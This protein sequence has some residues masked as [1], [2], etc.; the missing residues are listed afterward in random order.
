MNKTEDKRNIFNLIFENEDYEDWY[1]TLYITLHTAEPKT[2]EEIMSLIRY[3]GKV[4][5]KNCTD[6]SPIDIM[7][8]LCLNNEGWFWYWTDTKTDTE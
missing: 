7:D 2:E 4:N 5:E 6:Y 1:I 8:D 3:Y